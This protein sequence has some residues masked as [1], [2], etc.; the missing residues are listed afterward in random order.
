MATVATA[1]PTDAAAARPRAKTGLRSLPVMLGTPPMEAKLVDE[2]PDEEG[3]QFEP[4]W[5]GFRCLAYRAGT[6]VELQSK[7]GQVAGALLSGYRGDA[8]HSAA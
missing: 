7:S 3:W 5:D 8:P 4:K 1:R 2:L 6:E